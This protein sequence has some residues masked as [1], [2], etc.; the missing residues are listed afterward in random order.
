[1]EAKKQIQSYMPQIEQVQEASHRLKSVVMATPLAENLNLSEKFQANI[2]LKREDLQIVRSY[3]IRGAYNKIKSLSQKELKNGVVCASAGNH[4]QGVAYSCK[5]LG[6]KG[7]IFMPSPTP[8]QKI[9]QVKMFGKE[10]VDII[11]T[12]DT[13][14][15]AFEK[16][17]DYCK[18]KRSTFIHPFDDEKVIEGQATVGLEILNEAH[19]KIDYLFLPIGGGGLA[20]GILSVFKTLSPSTKIIGVEPEGAPAMKKS[21]ESGQIVELDKIDKFVDGAAVKRVGDLTFPICHKYLDEITTVPE[22]RICTTIL[23]LYNEEAIV[24]EPAGA[25]SISV[26]EDYR[27]KIKGKNVVCILSGSNNDI[28]R[29]EEIKERSLLYQGLKHYFI[30]R[31]PQRAGALK[32]FVND[33]LGPEDDIAHFEYT[34][35]N[36]RERGPA[37]IGI[38]LKQKEDFESL[39]QRMKDRNIVY[40]YLNEKQ[41]LFQFII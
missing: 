5:K 14:D 25:L 35:K 2:L 22:G 29:T 18:K 28:T 17:Q 32:E 36:S 3:K 41:D 38:E 1:M 24:V 12:G 13:Y 9:K 26:L 19:K 20:S 39:I 21:I 23:Q 6:I 7:I 8:R 37:V 15:D 10:M 34:K 16:S 40:E 11:L 4:A 33:V 31:F 27:K 30:V